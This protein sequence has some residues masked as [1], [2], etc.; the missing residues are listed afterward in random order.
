MLIRK[1]R[2]TTADSVSISY[3]DD[4]EQFHLR[5][6]KIGWEEPFAECSISEEMLTAML[7]HE[8]EDERGAVL[9]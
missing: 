1:G 5:L 9:Q 8:I 2:C 3:C 4:C 6:F 7:D